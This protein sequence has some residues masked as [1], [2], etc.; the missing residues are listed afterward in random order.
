VS[1]RGVT[2]YQEEESRRLF[3]DGRAAFLRNWTY[4]WR[5]LQREDSRVRGR[6]GVTLLPRDSAGR[7]AGTLGGWGLGI[8]RYSRS[9]DLA[10]AFILHVTTIE[11]QRALCEPTGYAPSTLAAYE[12]S[13]LLAANPFLAHFRTLHAGA[14]ARPA[15]PRYALAS[16]VLQRHLSAALAGLADPA[17]A[18]RDAARETRMLLGDGSAAGTGTRSR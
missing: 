3:A 12:D 2:T 17:D 16:D 8:S 6:V 18:L 7:P 5:L 13:T 10:F 9:P 11:S 15:L 4:V 14:V 1:P